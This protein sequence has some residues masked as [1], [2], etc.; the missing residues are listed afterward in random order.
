MRSVRWLAAALMFGPAAFVSSA[1]DAPP[2]PPPP[3][4]TEQAAP[5]PTAEEPAPPPAEHYERAVEEAGEGKLPGRRE[6]PTGW[7]AARPARPANV[8]P[9]PRPQPPHRGFSFRGVPA[10]AVRAS[11]LGVSTSSP[12]EALRR[13]LQ[14]KPGVGLVVEQVDPKSPADHAG[15]EQFDVLWKLGDQLL[16]NPE[17]LLVLVRT[18]KAGDEV[19][20]TVIRGGQ[21]QVLTAKLIEREVPP[22]RLL[23][24]DVDFVDGPHGAVHAPGKLAMVRRGAGGMGAAGAGAGNVLNRLRL[25]PG[26]TF[27]ERDIVITG[28][29]GEAQL[30]AASI[31]IE[32]AAHR[33]TINSKDGKKRLRVEDKSGQVVF[34]GPI[35][36]QEEL[37]KAPTDIREKIEKMGLEHLTLPEDD[38]SDERKESPAVERARD[39]QAQPDR[40]TAPPAKR[41]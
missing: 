15:V 9:P 18:F 5:A 8:P 7:R 28:D 26:R 3:P 1:Q 22:M 34:D 33:M 10:E 14:L 23:I 19:K 16:V 2:A 29:G 24:H 6:R 30:E 4:A 39:P 13:Q 38:G 21:P 40:E 17:Q 25:Q 35:Q 11:Y 41:Q 37:G 32:D 36:T 20:L 12:H 27:A 31:V